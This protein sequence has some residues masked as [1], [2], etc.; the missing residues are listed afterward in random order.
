MEEIY[1]RGKKNVI[2]RGPTV[3]VVKNKYRDSNYVCLEATVS[4]GMKRAIVDV[5]KN[6]G[7][8]EN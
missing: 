6:K 2:P 1:L 5:E 4:K 3:T 8:L 7:N